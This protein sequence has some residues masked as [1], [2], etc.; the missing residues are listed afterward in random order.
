MGQ[1]V[2]SVLTSE[3]FPGGPVVENQPS[4]AGDMGLIPGWGAK[5]SHASRQLSLSTATRENPN[6]AIKTHCGQKK[7]KKE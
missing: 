6:P 3:D 1:Y 4:I 2:I 7:K 5:I